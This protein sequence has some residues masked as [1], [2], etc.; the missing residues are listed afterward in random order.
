[1]S[2]LPSQGNIEMNTG[3]VVRSQRRLFA[4]LVAATLALAALFGP[5]AVDQMAGTG[6]TPSAAA[7]HGTTGGC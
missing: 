2:F 6:L 7:C 3:I 5:L 1:M 4:L